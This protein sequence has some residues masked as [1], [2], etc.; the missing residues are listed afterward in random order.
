LE[1]WRVITEWKSITEYSQPEDIVFPNKKGKRLDNVNTSFRNILKAAEISGFRFH[2]LRHH[3]AS[4]LV[5]E[6]VQLYTVKELLGHS[7]FKMTQR[8]THLAPDN[9]AEAVKALDN[10]QDRK[11]KKITTSNG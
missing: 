9:L 7:D 2:D 8:Y 1:G 6:G 4:S 5:Q 11:A 10:R 3:Y